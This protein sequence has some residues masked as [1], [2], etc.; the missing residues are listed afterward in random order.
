MSDS[1]DTYW[2]GEKLFGDDFSGSQIRDWF[3]DEQ[4][5]YHELDEG[6]QAQLLYAFHALN[7]YHGF[8]FISGLRFQRALGFGSS[9]G[10][11]FFPIAAQIDAIT[12]IEPSPQCSTTSVGGT[13]VEVVRPRPSG[14]FRFANNTFDLIVCLS[15]LHHV[16]NVSTVIGEMA[17]TS[18][19]GAYL[20]I[21]EPVVSMGD[22]R[23]PRKG[24]TRRER[25]IPIK[26]FRGMIADAG[27]VVQAEPLSRTI[28]PP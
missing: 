24:L 26:V 16:A 13:A 8:R 5:A 11:E 3:D 7:W 10:S 17:R 28:F 14:S 20:L 22:W 18:K 27:L 1:Y 25:G 9:Y 21:R 6:Y 23:K 2:T 19:P 12:L 4:N 15:A